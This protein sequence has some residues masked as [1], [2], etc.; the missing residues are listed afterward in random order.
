MSVRFIGRSYSG[1]GGGG[2]YIRGGRISGVVLV[3]Y[4]HAELN[5]V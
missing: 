2:G 1:G 5:Q 3:C 4:F